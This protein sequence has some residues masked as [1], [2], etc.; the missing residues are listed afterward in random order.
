MIVLPYTQDIAWSENFVSPSLLSYMMLITILL[1]F[2][3]MKTLFIN[4]EEG[5]VVKRGLE[6][7]LITMEGTFLFD[8]MPYTVFS[9]HHHC[10]SCH[11]V[12]S[13]SLN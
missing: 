2:P 8:K 11:A 1:Y 4:D 5:I 13:L 6:K 3:Q 9:T 10:K 12:P 7:I